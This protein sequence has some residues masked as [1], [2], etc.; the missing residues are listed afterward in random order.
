MSVP[1]VPIP[2]LLRLTDGRTWSGVEFEPGRFV[3]VYHP[4]EINL[5]SIAVTL[6][7]LLNVPEGHPLYGAKVE[8]R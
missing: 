2:F 5:C 1:A 7:D 6:T 3:C 8:E 4:D